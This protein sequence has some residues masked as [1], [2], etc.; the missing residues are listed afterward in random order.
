[1][2]VLI[3]NLA[4]II[5]SFRAHSIER[6]NIVPKYEPT[7]ENIFSGIMFLMLKIEMQF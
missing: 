7:K 1:M 4:S 5:I 6:I 2:I 3:P